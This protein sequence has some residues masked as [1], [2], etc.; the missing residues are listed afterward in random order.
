MSAVPRAC[1]MI[2][3]RSL[4]I[5]QGAIL[6]YRNPRVV[7]LFPSPP[8]SGP[9]I[10]FN[11]PFLTA[12]MHT[13]RFG[14]LHWHSRCGCRL[15][16]HLRTLRRPPPPKSSIPRSA[17]PSTPL[18]TGPSTLDTLTIAIIASSPPSFRSSDAS[19]LLTIIQLIPATPR[20]SS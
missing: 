7:Q 10:L 19:T 20:I 8:A 18:A 17:A 6:W 11:L 5:L 4:A 14:H 13:R 9:L 15:L 3:Q 16:L 12:R 1:S 2:N